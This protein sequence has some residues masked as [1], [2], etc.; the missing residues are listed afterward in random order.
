MAA[1][2]PSPL[3]TPTLAAPLGISAKDL[4]YQHPSSQGL[5]T[6]K[7][8]QSVNV[9]SGLA[10][11]CLLQRFV[12]KRSKLSLVK[13]RYSAETTRVIGDWADGSV[14]CGEAELVISEL[15]GG[16]K[17]FRS[18]HEKGEGPVEVEE[19][20]TYGRSC[21]SISYTYMYIYIYIYTCILLFVNKRTQKKSSDFQRIPF[22]RQPKV[23][24]TMAKSSSWRP[25]ARRICI[26]SR[27]LTTLGCWLVPLVRIAKD[28][29]RGQKMEIFE[30][31]L[32]SFSRL[33]F[34]KVE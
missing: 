32:V 9:V 30:M 5:S 27:Q 23:A 15:E 21:A 18:V 14:D 13:R 12:K 19:T 28:W 11:A 2:S 4:S 25:V 31:W 24:R 7:S 17:Q 10:A 3:T 1:L 29:A 8:R 33:F 16:I 34:L 20:H 6:S 26:S 22:L